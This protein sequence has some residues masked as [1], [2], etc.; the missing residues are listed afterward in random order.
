MLNLTSGCNCPPKTGRDCKTLPT[1]INAVFLALPVRGR[2]CAAR[3]DTRHAV[4]ATWPLT[5]AGHGAT[6]PEPTPCGCTAAGPPRPDGGLRAGGW[7][8]KFMVGK[9]REGG[10]RPA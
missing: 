3:S 10:G 8:D 4:G 2:V 9:R 1:G 6:C 5:T 7:P